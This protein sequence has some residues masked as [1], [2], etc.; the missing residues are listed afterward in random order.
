MYYF[1]EGIIR[2]HLLGFTMLIIRVTFHFP[3]LIRYRLAHEERMRPPWNTAYGPYSLPLRWLNV[4]WILSER[5]RRAQ[6]MG[7]TSPPP[8]ASGGQ[9]P[10]LLWNAPCHLQRPRRVLA[11]LSSEVMNLPM[12]LA[13]PPRCRPR[14]AG[15]G[16]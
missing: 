16:R 10:F 8:R 14:R 4:V 3:L 13:L 5:W 6:W 15:Q 1:M 11:P 2:V 12:S 9:L 7:A